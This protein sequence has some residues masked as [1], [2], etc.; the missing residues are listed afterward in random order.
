MKFFLQ[1]GI[2]KTHG[3]LGLIRLM[4]QMSPDLLWVSL[5]YR[6]VNDNLHEIDYYYA[7]F[8]S[9]GWLLVSFSWNS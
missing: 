4:L 1:A 3:S 5:H 7:T 6:P 9:V 2:E 8:C